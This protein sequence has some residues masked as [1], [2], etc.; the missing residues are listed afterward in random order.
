MACL[1]VL[2]VTVTVD[3]LVPFG[4]PCWNCYSVGY[5]SLVRIT[6]RQT[7]NPS[8]N[9]APWNKCSDVMF[10]RGSKI[11]MYGFLMLSSR[12][13]VRSLL[14]LDTLL[15]LRYLVMNQSY[16]CSLQLDKLDLVWYSPCLIVFWLWSKF[17]PLCVIIWSKLV[18]LRL[19]RPTSL[20][21]LLILL[22]VIKYGLVLPI[23][24]YR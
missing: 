22:L 14:V 24:P 11:G 19:S 8:D 18:R 13:T 12:L 9:T 4:N 20:A 6:R 3:L 7:G 17:F 15:S 16:R 5:R 23:W 10:H 1:H 21:V 2:W